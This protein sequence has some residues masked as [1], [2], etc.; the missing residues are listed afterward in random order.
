[1]AQA[2]IVDRK[3]KILVSASIIVISVLLD[4]AVKLLAAQSLRG[5]PG[6]SFFGDVLRFEYAE[7]TGAFLS[8]G[9]QLDQGM[10][11]LFFI[12]GVVVIIGCCVVWLLRSASNWMAIVALS[13]VI[14]GGVGNLIDRI[15]RGSVIDFIYIGVGPLHT[16]VFNIADMAI[17]GGL[18]L[19]LYEQY[20]AEKK[21][22]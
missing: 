21:K 7:N 22:P 13:S 19:M 6:L 14:S 2:K 8:L 4:Q 17:T 11:T 18:M 10:R 5:R 1:M 9:A 15:W 12:L 3:T 16:G 20:L